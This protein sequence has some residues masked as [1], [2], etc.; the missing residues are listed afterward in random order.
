MLSHVHRSAFAGHVI[1]VR[2]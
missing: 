1:I 2:F